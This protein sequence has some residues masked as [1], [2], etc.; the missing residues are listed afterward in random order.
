M[1]KKGFRP[2]S[3]QEDQFEYESDTVERYEMISNEF[4]YEE[5]RT[6]ERFG[7]K[8]YRDCIYR[9]QLANNK[10]FRE[11]L[12]VLVYESG[13]IYEGEWE[14]NKRHGRGYEMFANGNMYH[15]SY[16]EGKA[17]GKGVY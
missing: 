13:R 10:K 3:Q 11:G 16:K 4:N 12:G 17:H 7:I 1:V 9:G 8:Q 2:S 6:G 15:G 5:V 14:A